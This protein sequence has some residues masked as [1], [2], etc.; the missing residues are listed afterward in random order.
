M[1]PRLGLAR[2]VVWGV[3]VGGVG[4]QR[5]GPSGRMLRDTQDPRGVAWT[6]G[7]RCCVPAQGGYC[8][9]PASPIGRRRCVE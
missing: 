8:V 3:W 9:A 5:G 1:R 2:L 6:G 4:K 7:W